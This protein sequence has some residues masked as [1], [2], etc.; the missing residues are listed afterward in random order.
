MNNSSKGHDAKKR[1]ADDG[2]GGVASMEGEGLARELMSA[3]NQLLEQNRSQMAEMK[4][5]RGDMKSIK[6][7]MK[8]M[9]SEVIHLRQKCDDAEN[10][11]KYHEV[12]LKNQKWQYSAPFPNADSQ[13]NRFL[14]RIKKITCDMRYG[15]CDGRVTIVGDLTE[16]DHRFLP[17][18]KEFANALEEYHYALKCLPKETTSHLVI[19]DVD[20]PKIVL[21]LLSNALESTQFKSIRLRGNNFGRNG[22][23]FALNYMQHNPT[24]EGIIQSMTKMMSISSVK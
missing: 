18:W 4:S 3:M 2:G 19:G 5:M 10:R 21:G 22:I 16:Y 14:D 24:L 1:K 20:L 23:Q 12:L 13:E 15:K 8:D 17:N 7:E 11:Q 9:R 6:D